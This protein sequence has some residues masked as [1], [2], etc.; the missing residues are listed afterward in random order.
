MAGNREFTVLWQV[1]V[2]ELD[3]MRKFSAVF[4]TFGDVAHFFWTAFSINEINGMMRLGYFGQVKNWR[5]SLKIEE[6]GCLEI[7]FG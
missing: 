6:Y 3:A 2:R 4:I 7:I 5:N 1:I